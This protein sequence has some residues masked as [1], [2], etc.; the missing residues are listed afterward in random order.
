MSIVPDLWRDPD[1]VPLNMLRRY[2]TA[3]GWRK[4]P[5]PALPEIATPRSAAARTLI[6]TMSGGR[7]TFDVYV[8][9]ETDL[10]D[11]ELVLPYEKSA[12]DYSRQIVNAIK[13]LS[14]LEGRDPEKVIAAIRLIGFDVMQSR[15]PDGMV[16]ND[17]IHLEVA[18]GYVA[19]ARALLAATATTEIQPDPYFLR[20][21]KEAS[22]YANKCRFGHTFKGS[23]G[24]TVESP[25]TPNNEPTLAQIVQAPP[26]ERRVMQRIVRGFSA[27]CDAVEADD[28][29]T[30]VDGAST[31]FSANSCEFFA[32]LVEETA[33]GGLLFAFQLSPEWPTAVG[34][35]QTNE[36]LVGPRH[37]EIT[38]AAAKVLREQYVPTFETLIGRIVGLTSDGNPSDLLN[39]MGDR[40]I[41]VQWIA[42][43]HGEIS[44]KVSLN[45]EEYLQAV[46]AHRNGRLIGVSGTLERK[47]R[48][49]VL[50][51][52]RNFG[53]L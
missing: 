18:A 46:D 10:P 39:P 37:V 8:L 53:P 28:T 19:G 22:E 52:P 23:F 51:G 7:R 6:E 33:P 35:A 41:A 48:T 42:S 15:I 26:F 47:G 3:H 30:L 40:E 25:V 13:T 9:S 43:D 24:F 27:V 50:S 34:L 36:F 21:K 2:L 20:V 29:R 16:Y 4:P 44:V 32:K 5:L 1:A 14:E 49:W 38:R 12:P 11:I 31:G 45:A 17:T